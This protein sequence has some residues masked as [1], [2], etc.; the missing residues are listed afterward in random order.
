M[1][2]LLTCNGAITYS[3]QGYADCLAG[4]TVVQ[5]VPPFAI[6]DIDPLVFVTYVG[7]GFFLLLPLYVAIIGGRVI[8]KS[9]H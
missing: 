4:W 3:A 1:S 6:T 8:L 2:N 5:Y 7:S 9:I